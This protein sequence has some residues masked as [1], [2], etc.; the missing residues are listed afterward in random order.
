MGCECVRPTRRSFF[1]IKTGSLFWERD[2]GN[3][4]MWKDLNPLLCG[5]TEILWWKK[6]KHSCQ[7][8]IYIILYVIVYI[9]I[10]QNHPAITCFEF[11]L[12]WGSVHW[13]LR[14]YS[15]NFSAMI[16]MATI[17]SLLD[18]GIYVMVYL[19]R[20]IVKQHDFYMICTCCI[21][22]MYLFT[23]LHRF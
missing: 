14:R 7:I 20:Y 18:G 23:L 17:T 16:A 6:N 15:H 21:F 11:T 10:Y 5:S 2:F 22:Y 8:Y 9:H 12:L 4:D 13:A 1:G 3:F 19:L